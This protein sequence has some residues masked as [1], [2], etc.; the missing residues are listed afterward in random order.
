MPPAAVPRLPNKT[1]DAEKLSAPAR[2]MRKLGLVRDVDVAL[3]L[4][5]RYV[6]ETRITPIG[7]LRDGASGQIQGVVCDCRVETR[8][9]RQLVV[10]LADDSGELLLRLLHFYP[11]HQKTLAVGATVRGARRGACRL[12]RPRDGAPRRSASSPQARRF[13]GT[14]LTPVYPSSAALPQAYLRKAV[15]SALQPRAAG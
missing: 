15:A 14:A 5:M 12:L 1:A 6:D 4:P 3:H 9:R 8:A 2:A 10:R 13:P 11:S 7:T